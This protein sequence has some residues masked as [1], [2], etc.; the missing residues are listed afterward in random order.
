MVLL[1]HPCIACKDFHSKKTEGSQ[2]NSEDVRMSGLRLF[3]ESIK[4]KGRKLT[5]PSYLRT[6]YAFCTH[7]HGIIKRCK[8]MINDKKALFS[9][10]PRYLRK[11][12][13][14]RKGRKMMQ[15]YTVSTPC[16]SGKKYKRCC[17]R[18]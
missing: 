15:K 12:A 18:K 10:I 13:S 3:V 11:V 4:Q 8:K 7:W 9:L 17:G 1:D 16:G 5:C 6:V 2:Q 14:D